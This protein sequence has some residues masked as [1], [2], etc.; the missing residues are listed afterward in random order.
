MTTTVR[1][2]NGPTGTRALDAANLR[3][4]EGVPAVVDVNGHD[5]RRGTVR[6]SYL[7]RVV[8]VYGTRG[9]ALELEDLGRVYVNL[10]GVTGVGPTA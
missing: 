6:G 1:P 4:L 9:V 10:S 8:K 5:E 3:R 7:G 2:Y